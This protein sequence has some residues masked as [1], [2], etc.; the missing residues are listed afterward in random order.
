[1]NLQQS[2]PQADNNIPGGSWNGCWG[3][4]YLMKS[5]TSFRFANQ[6][7]KGFIPENQ[8]DAQLKLQSLHNHIKN[9][10]I[11]IF[12]AAEANVNWTKTSPFNVRTLGLFEARRTS[13]SYLTAFPFP[14]VYQL[15]GTFIIARDQWLIGLS[16]LTAMQNC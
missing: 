12:G 2:A 7:I 14:N 13:V 9:Y 10:N 11:D 3:D 16:N 15:G 8:R 6:N 1:M 5:K 4:S